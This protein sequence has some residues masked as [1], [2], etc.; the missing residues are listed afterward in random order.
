MYRR[1]AESE[2]KVM[3]MWAGAGAGAFLHNLAV[4]AQVVTDNFAVA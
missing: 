4:R 1:D 3:H 2:K